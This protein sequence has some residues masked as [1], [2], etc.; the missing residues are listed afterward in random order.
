MLVVSQSM[1]NCS[2]TQI[3]SCD[4][5]LHQSVRPGTSGRDTA[6][7]EE[8]H[9]RSCGA[10]SICRCHAARLCAFVTSAD[11]TGEYVASTC[12]QKECQHGVQDYHHILVT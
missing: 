3:C 5:F 8:S 2:S 11:S 12:I 10:S 6:S 9:A 1:Q 4:V 7:P